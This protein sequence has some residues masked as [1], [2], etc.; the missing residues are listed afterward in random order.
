MVGNYVD[1]SFH[2]H[3]F[4]DIGGTITTID[5]PGSTV[6]GGAT[7]VG[8]IN[9]SGWILGAYEDPNSSYSFAEQGFLDISGTISTIDVPNSTET[10]PSA[11]NASGE[12]VGPRTAPEYSMV[13][14]TSR[15]SSRMPSLATTS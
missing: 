6:A 9:A 14:S 12:I 13:I 4:L 7:A 11:I 15:P 5:V 3:G 1:S 2:R 10:E 8:S